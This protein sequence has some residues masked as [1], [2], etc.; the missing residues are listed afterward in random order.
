M[1]TDPSIEFYKGD[2]VHSVLKRYEFSDDEKRIIQAAI[3]TARKSKPSIKLINEA[4]AL[5]NKISK[6]RKPL[7]ITEEADDTA[8]T[9]AKAQAEYSS[10]AT[11]TKSKKIAREGN[12]MLVF[13][14]GMVLIVF[15][16]IQITQSAQA[17]WYD[18]DC[19]S[20]SYDKI[21]QADTR[22]RDKL[23]TV[24][25]IN[26]LYDK[27]NLLTRISAYIKDKHYWV[28]DGGKLMIYKISDTKATEPANNKLYERKCIDSRSFLF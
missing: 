20:Y 8:I 14:A 2:A 1:K 3:L 28:E 6:T 18:A 16:T 10:L 9:L 22:Y 4:D 23:P 7:P 21:R 19:G 17:E 12:R 5:L 24:A 27:S 15:L 26:E 25:E 13:F 11:S